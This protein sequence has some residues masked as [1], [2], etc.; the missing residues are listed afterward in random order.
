M[1]NYNANFIGRDELEK[2]PFRSLGKNVLIDTSVKLIE[3]ENIDIGDDVRIDAGTI[4][5]A[6]GKVYI[7][8]FVHIAANCYL[9]GRAGIEMYD[10][11]GLSSFV[12]LHS[13]SDDFTGRSLTNPT[14]PEE[15]KKLKAGRI[16]LD[17]H[18]LIGAK[19]TI[20]PGVTVEEGGVLGGHSLARKNVDAWTI[21]A[22]TPAA[23]VTKRR[24]DLLELEQQFLT[25]RREQSVA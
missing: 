20:L 6:S 4:I 3:V 13:V 8:S 24:K 9:E 16:V 21:H 22:G 17:R 15:Y 12:S 10:F 19:A 5:I 1:T 11:S 7:G 2:I 14:V 23:F 25:R 18:A